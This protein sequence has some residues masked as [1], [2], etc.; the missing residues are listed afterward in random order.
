MALDR[1]WPSWHPRQELKADQ[2]LGLEDYLLAR[3]KLI[4]EEAYGVDHFNWRAGLA[5]EKSEGEEGLYRV[6]VSGLLRGVTPAGDLVEVRGETQLSGLTPTLN[7]QRRDD[8]DLWIEVN[9]RRVAEEDGPPKFVLH[10]EWQAAENREGGSESLTLQKGG[11]WLYLGR[12]HPS[13]TRHHGCVLPDGAPQ[14]RLN[15]EKTPAGGRG[16]TPFHPRGKLGNG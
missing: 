6:S 13:S 10:A 1:E 8:L 16:L 5:I 7:L 2:L 12:Y 11:H 15:R 3:A 14:G 4:D 9:P